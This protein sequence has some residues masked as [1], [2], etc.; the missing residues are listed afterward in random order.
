LAVEFTRNT[1]ARG[2]EFDLELST[3][4]KTWKVEPSTSAVIGAEG[5]GLEKVI[6]RE[7]A[8]LDGSPRR[9]VRLAV[10]VA[11]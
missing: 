6:L 5:V 1:L 8:P 7:T 9:F 3:D 2:I 10:R 11:P 4:L